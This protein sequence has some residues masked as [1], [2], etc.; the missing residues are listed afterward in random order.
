MGASV[1]DSGAATAQGVD[2]VQLLK[3]VRA[4]GDGL[5]DKATAYLKLVL[6]IGYASFYT[7]WSGTKDQMGIGAK[8]S[9]AA[10]M[11]FSVFVYILAEVY[12]MRQQSLGVVQF[13]LATANT[14]PH[15]VKR[16]LDKFNEDNAKRTRR[17]MKIFKY[18]YWPVLGPAVV[19]ATIMLS[20][21]AI[22]LYHLWI[23]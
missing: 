20:S 9:S 18:I 10:L 4:F 2:G 19:A 11:T 8:I 23:R 7:V 1:G 13:N 12:Q 21:F 6:G 16:A 3:E 15:E 14:T 22:R 5:F 17:S